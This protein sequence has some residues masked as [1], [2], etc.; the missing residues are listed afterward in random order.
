MTSEELAHVRESNRDSARKSRERK[1][2]KA[3]DLQNAYNE[4][5]KKLKKQSL[6]IEECLNRISQLENENAK[7]Q[8]YA[9]ANL[10]NNVYTTTVSPLDF[11]RYITKE[12]PPNSYTNDM[13]ATVNS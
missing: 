3:L 4:Q 2:L 8:S 5:E 12:K 6:I 9:S 7:L 13:F 11:N 10:N 1:R